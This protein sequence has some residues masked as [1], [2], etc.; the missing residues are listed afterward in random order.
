[1]TFEKLMTKEL[2]K[3]VKLFQKYKF[4]ALAISYLF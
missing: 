3:N 1:M 2:L 4:F